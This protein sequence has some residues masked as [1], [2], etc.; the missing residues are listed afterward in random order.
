VVESRLEGEVG[1]E[2]AFHQVIDGVVH[3]SGGIPMSGYHLELDGT[4][5]RSEGSLALK[6]ALGTVAGARWYEG[7]GFLASATRDN[8]G[9]VTYQFVGTYAMRSDQVQV[10][11]A[12]LQGRMVALISVWRDGTIYV[13]AFTMLEATA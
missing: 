8:N 7:S 1:Q 12:P 10:P 2:I 6:F 11:G 3:D 4:V 13:G 5:Q 9:S